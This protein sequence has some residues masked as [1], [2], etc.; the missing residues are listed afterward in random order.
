MYLTGRETL[1]Q[2]HEVDKIKWSN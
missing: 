2:L 1:I